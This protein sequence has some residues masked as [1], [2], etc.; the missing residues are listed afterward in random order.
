MTYSIKYLLDR[1]NLIVKC[2]Q[3]VHILPTELRTAEL[4]AIAFL[5]CFKILIL[6]QKNKM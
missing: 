6:T 5:V 3:F 4:L 1:G 2:V